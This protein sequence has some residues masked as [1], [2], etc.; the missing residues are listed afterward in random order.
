MSRNNSKQANSIIPPPIIVSGPSFTIYGEI[1]NDI[2][3]RFYE[4]LYINFTD[5]DHILL[6]KTTDPELLELDK[7]AL[8]IIPDINVYL[9]TIGGSEWLYTKS[10]IYKEQFEPIDI[11]IEYGYPSQIQLRSLHELAALEPLHFL[12]FLKE[13]ISNIVKSK[14]KLKRPCIKEKFNKF[15]PII[16]AQVKSFILN[17][18]ENVIDMDIVNNIKTNLQRLGVLL[19][20]ANLIDIINENEQKRRNKKHLH[21]FVGARHALNLYDCLQMDNLQIIKTEKGEQIEPLE[22]VD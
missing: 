10:L 1:H 19:V 8:K 17:L 20:D 2:D 12:A 6:E 13:K 11:R 15:V 14:E 21:I 3:N 9:N 18:Q 16:Q 22:P 4:N 5:D 7:Q